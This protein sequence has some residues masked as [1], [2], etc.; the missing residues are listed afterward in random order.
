MIRIYL[1][2]LSVCFSLAASAADLSCRKADAKN[3]V[4]VVSHGLQADYYNG[5]NFEEKVYSRIEKQIDFWWLKQTP[6]P[7]VNAEDFSVRWTGK[8]RAPATGVYTFSVRAD[9]GI[10]LWIGNMLVLDEWHLQQETYYQR[11]VSLKENQMYNLKV[12][13]YNHELHAVMQLFWE[14]PVNPQLATR[15]Q[16]TII[17]A[18]YFYTPGSPAQSIVSRYTSKP[19]LHTPKTPKPVRIA[20]RPA[21]TRQPSVARKATSLPDS[22]TLPQPSAT[23]EEWLLGT[24]VVLQHVL[25]EQSRYILLPASYPELDK[26]VKTLQKYPRL[27]MVI[28]GHTDNMGDPRLN[29]ALSENRAQVIFNYLIRQGIEPTRLEA[30]GYGSSRPIADNSVETERARNRRVEFTVVP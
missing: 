17:P 14:E 16:R 11:K 19:L 5:M 2:L 30:K 9:D 7:G 3:S 25:F 28:G 26:L 22:A 12:E 20:P 10:R 27:R 13:Y 24:S 1:F 6:A 29:Q 23:A 4:S 18:E 21:T 8:L 15:P